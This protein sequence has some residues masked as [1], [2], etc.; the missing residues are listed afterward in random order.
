MQFPQ[1]QASGAHPPGAGASEG[2][3]TARTKAPATDAPA[4]D[5]PPASGLRIWNAGGNHWH[6]SGQ[7]DLRTEPALRA[8]MR[9]ASAT[10]GGLVLNCGELSFIDVAGLRMIARTARGLDAPVTVNGANE[11]LR[12]AWSLLDLHVAA[13]NVEFS[14]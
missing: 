11:S 3:D 8:A 9:T 6:L 13:P 7:A 5:S 14:T 12:R 4:T 1:P 10:G 2:D